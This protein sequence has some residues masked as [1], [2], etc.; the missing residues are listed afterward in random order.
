[1]PFEYLGFYIPNISRKAGCPKLFKYFHTF[2][3]KVEH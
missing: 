1:M 2:Q 3:V